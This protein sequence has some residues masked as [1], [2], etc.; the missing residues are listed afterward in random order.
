MVQL[1]LGE[2]GQN[3]TVV[4]IDQVPVN[5]RP[6]AIDIRIRNLAYEKKTFRPT[7]PA[8]CDEIGEALWTVSFCKP[9]SCQSYRSESAKRIFA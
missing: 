2:L 7:V 4:P 1:L 9:W 5:E 3:G 6:I 8:C